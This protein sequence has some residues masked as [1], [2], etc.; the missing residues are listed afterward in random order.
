MEIR[1]RYEGIEEYAVW[2]VKRKA[3]QLVGTHRFTEGDRDDLEQEMMLDAPS[4][5]LLRPTV[6]PLDLDLELRE[7]ERGDDDEQDEKKIHASAPAASLAGLG[8]P[9]ATHAMIS[10]RHANSRLLSWRS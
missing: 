1:N 9:W 3:K 7:N 4:R 8:C 2:F 6:R 5:E 10:S